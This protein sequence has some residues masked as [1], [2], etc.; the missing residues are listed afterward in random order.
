MTVDRLAYSLDPPTVIAVVDFDGARASFEVA[1]GD[2]ERISI[3]DEVEFSFRRL[4]TSD[5]IHNYFWKAV[6]RR[7][8]IDPETEH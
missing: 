7:R 4:H 8:T 2:R 1:D 5:G 3:G 6:P